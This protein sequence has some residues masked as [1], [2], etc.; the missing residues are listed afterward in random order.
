MTRSGGRP[1]GGA[2]PPAA[3]LAGA[4]A[5]AMLAAGPEAAGAPG[6][7]EAGEG[8]QAA[9][10]VEMTN[11]LAFTPDSVVIRAGQS[12][13]FRNSSALVH[14]VTGDPSKATLDASVRLPDGAEPFDSGRLEP[15]E[16]YT[17]TFET[18]GRYRYFCVPHEGAR[19]RG[20]VVVKPASGGDGSPR[21]TRD[22]TAGRGPSGRGPGP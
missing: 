5:L 19:M 13:E 15:G 8:R 14:T 3:A 9:A 16:D 18:P 20:T 1:P 10:T 17:R 11:E 21:G 12:V 22:P 2:S 6:P 4:A 7:G